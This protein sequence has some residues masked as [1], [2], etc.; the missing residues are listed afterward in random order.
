MLTTES[1]SSPAEAPR[2]LDILA[3][4]LSGLCLVHCIVLPA[5]AALM[6]L[7]A[8][9]HFADERVHLWLL[10]AVVPTS[11]MAL[12][13]GYRHHHHRPLIACGLLGLGLVAFA[14]LGR[15]AG[16]VD[17]SGDRW[18]SV[19]GGIILALVHLRNFRLLHAIRHP[20]HRRAAEVAS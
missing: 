2:S 14:A 15:N 7:F 18:F 4:L 19:T 16:V 13:F 8:S 6:P 11:L 9:E 20:H 17:E 3:M 1:D 12:G 5:L 10:V